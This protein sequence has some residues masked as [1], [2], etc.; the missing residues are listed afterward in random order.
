MPESIKSEST[1]H[2]SLAA[3]TQALAA[4]RGKNEAEVQYVGVE[5]SNASPL[6]QDVDTFVG[7]KLEI[8]ALWSFNNSSLGGYVS[9]TF[10][11]SSDETL[12]SLA[13][14][15]MFD[16]HYEDSSWSLGLKLGFGYLFTVDENPAGVEGTIHASYMPF[17]GGKLGFVSEIG[18][19]HTGLWATVAASIGIKGSLDL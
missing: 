19:I 16:H 3:S 11:L 12:D 17:L 10:P 6:K 1:D 18:I 15:A 7:V 14:G 8:D 2:F 4:Y 5:P 13:I 9:T